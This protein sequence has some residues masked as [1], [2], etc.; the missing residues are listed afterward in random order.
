MNKA[1]AIH[2]NQR[3]IQEAEKKIEV[4]KGEIA[5]YVIDI[6]AYQKVIC[7]LEEDV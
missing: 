6:K 3:W 7:E 5:V 1:D 4:L 2:L